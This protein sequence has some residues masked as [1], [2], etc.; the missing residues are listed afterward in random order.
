MEGRNLDVIHVTVMNRKGND[1]TDLMGS[2]VA[3]SATV[4][5]GER[6]CKGVGVLLSSRLVNAAVEYKAIKPRLP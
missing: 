3:F 5:A 1:T 6:R 4:P 2:W